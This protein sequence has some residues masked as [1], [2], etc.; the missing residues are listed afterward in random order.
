MRGPFLGGRGFL[1]LE[2]GDVLE[3][4]P[5]QVG[6]VGHRLGVS[7]LLFGVPQRLVRR[8]PPERWLITNTYEQNK[9]SRIMAQIGE[10]QTSCRGP[11]VSGASRRAPALTAPAGEEAPS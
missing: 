1:P 10:S 11:L 5:V 7:Y 4:R 3:E 2:L 9:I 6:V 8:H